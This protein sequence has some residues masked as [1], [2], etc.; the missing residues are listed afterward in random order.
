VDTVSGQPRTRNVGFGRAIYWYAEHLVTTTK[1]RP[2]IL[3]APKRVYIPPKSR[4]DT[5]HARGCGGGWLAPWERTVYS[6][7][8]W[9]RHHQ[10]SRETDR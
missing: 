1:N 10:T 3:P 4:K 9:S 2:I 6:C 5:R 8:R 7:S